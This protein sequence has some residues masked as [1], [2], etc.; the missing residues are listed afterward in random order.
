MKPQRGGF[1]LGLV[2]GLLIGLALALGVALYVTKV[3]V[4]F[5]NKVPQR[6]AEQDAAEA[7]RNKQLG[8]E[9]PL[10]GKAGAPAAGRQ[11]R[12][13]AASAPRRCADA[14][15]WPVQ[16]CGRRARAA[17][18]RRRPARDPAAILAGR[19]PPPPQRPRPRLRPSCSSCRPAPSPGRRRRAA[20]RQ[21]GLLGQRQGDRARTGGRTV[22]RVRIGP[23]DAR[24]E[25]DG[26]RCKPGRLR[27]RGAAGAGG[28]LSR[29]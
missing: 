23:F 13:A 10:A 2:V 12:G 21:A 15:R 3:P 24:A 7:E 20:A 11:R 29:Q 27:H 9:R 28:T 19:A 5:V 22:Y 6:T 25:A 18:G 14:H 8:P 16:P 4:P 17:A 1:A 26:P